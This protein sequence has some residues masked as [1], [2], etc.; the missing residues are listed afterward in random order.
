MEQIHHAKSA[1]KE[2]GTTTAGIRVV[3]PLRRKTNTN[4]STSEMAI[5]KVRSISRTEA[6]MVVVR[7]RTTKKLMAAGMEAFSEGIAALIRSTVSMIFAPGW[8]KMISGMLGRPFRKPAARMFSTLLDVGDI[9]QA[10]GRSVVVSDN[11][12]LV[13]TWL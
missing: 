4:N 1:D 3:R 6:R 9:C 5:S 2:T 12:W 7:S 13:V 11:Q 8:R 10:D